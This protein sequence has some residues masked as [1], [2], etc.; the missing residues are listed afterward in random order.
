MTEADSG[1]VAT[2]AGAPEGGEAGPAGA[3]GAT[4][5]PKQ[6]SA[7]EAADNEAGDGART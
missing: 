3:A 2:E 6:Q 5:I 4:E 7:D 1:T